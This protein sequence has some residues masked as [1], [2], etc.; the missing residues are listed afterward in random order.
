MIQMAAYLDVKVLAERGVGDG[1]VVHNA[2][3]VP[4]ATLASPHLAGPCL[5]HHDTLHAIFCTF[6]M[7]VFILTVSG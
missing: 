1:G 4:L 3:P 7:F 5:H 2:Q 6:Y